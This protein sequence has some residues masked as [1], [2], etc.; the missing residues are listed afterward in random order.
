MNDIMRNEDRWLDDLLHEPIPVED[1]A[2]FEKRVLKELARR[3]WLRIIVLGIAISL[4]MLAGLSFF[5]WES[6]QQVLA[7]TSNVDWQGMLPDM[8]EITPYSALTAGLY[9]LA[10]LVVPLLA[11]SDT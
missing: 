11:L 9:I 4:G 8:V 5:P 1:S 3:K 7:L 10:L 2:A 6:A